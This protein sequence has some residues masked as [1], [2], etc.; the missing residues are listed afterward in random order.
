MHVRLL[1]AALGVGILGGCAT[2]PYASRAPWEVFVEASPAGSGLVHVRTHTLAPSECYT[3]GE[4]R[5]A[6][7]SQ[8]QSIQVQAVVAEAR[9][10]Y[11]EDDMIEVV[12]DLPGL[13]LEPD[14][15]FLEVVVS[16]NGVERNRVL[17][18]LAAAPPV[19]SGYYGGPG[20]NNGPYYQPQPPY[21]RTN[22]PYGG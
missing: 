13:Q 16:A 17:I 1:A 22:P 11:C 12:H 9:G 7:S 21:P 2:G 19:G 5:S 4:I 20:Y 14:D 8:A 18:D 6:P 3:A 10:A 15:R